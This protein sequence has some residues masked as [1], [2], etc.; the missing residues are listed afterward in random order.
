MLEW[1]QSLSAGQLAAL[2]AGSGWAFWRFVK[3]LNW[4]N[5]PP[6]QP[7]SSH[8]EDRDAMSHDEITIDDFCDRR[9]SAR[10]NESKKEV[11]PAKVVDTQEGVILKDS[12]LF[13]LEQKYKSIKVKKGCPK[14]GFIYAYDGARCGHCLPSAVAER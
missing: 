2:A 7:V 8:D 5:A 10:L 13:K 12:H 11:A 9:W 4:N 1:L 14:C 6:P 3:W